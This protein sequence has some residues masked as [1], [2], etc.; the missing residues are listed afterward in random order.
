MNEN[1]LEANMKERIAAVKEYLKYF[2]NDSNATKNLLLCEYSDEI[3]VE[4]GNRYYPKIE[5]GYF[6]INN[7]IKAG[8][9]Y[10]LTNTTTSYEQNKQDTII[11]WDEPCGRLAFVKD[12]YWNSIDEEWAEFMEV[13]KSY[14]PL[15][16]DPLNNVY[17]YD[18]QNGKRLIEDYENIKS[19]FIEKVEKKIK[20]AD[21]ERKKRELE[22]LQAEINGSME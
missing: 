10:H 17:I 8:K 4:L 3:G 9:Y 15:D 13:L 21:I 22:K 11:I 2:P 20:Y 7:Q 18:L 6:V 12:I 16:Y 14:N 5:Y 19:D 1:E